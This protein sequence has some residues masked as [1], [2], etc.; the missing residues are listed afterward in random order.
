MKRAMRSVRLLVV[1]VLTA[2]LVFAG[3]GCISN[4]AWRDIADTSAATVASTVLD[5]TLIDAMECALTDDCP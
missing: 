2:V 3:T 4:K 1:P 5:L